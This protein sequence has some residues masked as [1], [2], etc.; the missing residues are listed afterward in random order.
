M[1]LRRTT[2]LAAPPSLASALVLGSYV[3]TAG[4]PLEMVRP[5]AVATVAALSVTLIGW[6][7]VRQLLLAVWIGVVL[8]SWIL[9]RELALLSVGI[10]LGIIAVQLYRRWRNLAPVSVS[11]AFVIGPPVALLGVAIYQLVAGGIVSLDDFPPDGP[12]RAA[13][14]LEGTLPSMY[15]LLLDGYPRADEL[16]TA[17][18]YDN[19]RFI[20]ELDDLGFQ[21]HAEATS[22]FGGTSW[23]LASTMLEDAAELHPYADIDSTPD[24]WATL[25][26][27]RRQYLVNVP[28]MDRLRGA[29]YRLEYVAPGVDLSEWRGWDRTHD[30]GQLT[31]TEALLIQRSPLKQILGDWLMDQLRSRI[32]ASLRTWAETSEDPRQKVSFAHIMSPHMPFLWGSEGRELPPGNCWYAR[33]CSLFTVLTE[34]LEMSHDEYGE[35]LGWQLEAINQRVLGPVRRIVA[36]DPS[37]IVV[38]MSDHGARFEPRSPER[39]HTFLATRIPHDPNLL[40]SEPGP[41]TLFVRLLGSLTQ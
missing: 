5:L 9:G 34:E 31:D 22:A 35:H 14:A 16:Q 37:A 24:L 1:N 28:M 32:G 7:L 30:S 40:T 38:I 36:A 10:G 23:T 41:D 33:R 12:P 2:L 18:G 39:F 19:G 8:V 20:E 13:T 15:V 4:H 27:L 26:A 29:G 25:R 11:T 17:F 6:A 3:Q 21:I